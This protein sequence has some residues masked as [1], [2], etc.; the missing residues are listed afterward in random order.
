VQSN[1]AVPNDEDG[2]MT[3]SGEQVRNK[4]IF[5]PSFTLAYM[6]YWMALKTP[7]NLKLNPAP[8]FSAPYLF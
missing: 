7:V 2:C 6:S 4:A 1:I 3:E 8:F 5:L